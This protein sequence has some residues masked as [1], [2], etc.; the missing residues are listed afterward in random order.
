MVPEIAQFACPALVAYSCDG[1]AVFIAADS[2][3]FMW[4]AIAASAPLDAMGISGVM[5]DEKM[6]CPITTSATAP[7]IAG[8]FS[9]VIV[10]ASLVGAGP[11]NPPPPSSPPLPPHAA[12]STA[13]AAT[14]RRL[15]TRFFMMISLCEP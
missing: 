7:A 12:N 1:A 4:G 15:R 9:T 5:I 13:P 3:G 14:M 8:A 11:V 6:P 2:T 10:A